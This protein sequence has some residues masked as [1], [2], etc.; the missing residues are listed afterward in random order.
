MALELIIYDLDGTLLDAF[1]DIALCINEGLAAC[2]LPPYD[3]ETVKT[4]VGH[5]VDVAIKKALA[6]HGLNHFDRVKGVMAECYESPEFQKGMC[7]P[8]VLHTLEAMRARG[9]KQVIITNKPQRIADQSCVRIGVTERV[10]LVVGA[11]EGIELKPDAA[12]LE[13][14]EREIG[15]TR[16]SCVI[17]GDGDADGG[18]ALAS[19]I[20]FIA[21]T[22]GTLS[23][24]ALAEF[25]PA[26]TINSVEELQSA[27][28]NLS[29]K[30]K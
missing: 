16:G 6:P 13:I 21:C 30:M 12:M 15:I 24:E 11:R 1:G 19:G 17:V 25:N 5:G 20:P 23:A 9:F 10:D 3:V 26:S 28:I 14:V 4:F 8:G 7:Y 27:L 18:L 29:E 2:E 22:W